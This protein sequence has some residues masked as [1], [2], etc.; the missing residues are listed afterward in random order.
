M[1]TLGTS[2]DNNAV[3]GVIEAHARQPRLGDK[4]GASGIETALAMGRLAKRLEKL[5]DV[6][7]VVH[8]VGADFTSLCCL[9]TK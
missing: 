3:A 7:E 2:R 1:N 5:K 4:S 6:D 9:K 8:Q